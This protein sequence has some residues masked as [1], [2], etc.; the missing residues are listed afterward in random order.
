MRTAGEDFA[1]LV[2]SCKVNGIDVVKVIGSNG[3]VPIIILFTLAGGKLRG[4][5]GLCGG[6]GFG[7]RLD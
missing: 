3:P 7:R 5:G 1:E 2:I 6:N 4:L